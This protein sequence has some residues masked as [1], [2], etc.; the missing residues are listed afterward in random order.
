MF[1]STVIPAYLE[2]E[3][4]GELTDR[5]IKSLDK[6]G[7]EYQIL[8][9]IQ[10]DDGSKEFLDELNNPKV[11]YLYHSKPIGVS[12]A[13]IDGFK[14]VIDKSDLILTMDAD[15]NHQPEE[16][17]GLL[18]KLKEK[19]ADITIGSRYIAGGK[20]IGMPLW[21]KLLSRF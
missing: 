4:L 1:I 5:L 17:A 18:E 7:M 21:K 14:E 9:V 19:D 12:G 20:I 6:S 8:Y 16:I 2:K 10:G 11:K 15:L 3:N 13:F